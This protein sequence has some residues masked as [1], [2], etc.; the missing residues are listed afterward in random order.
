MDFREIFNSNKLWEFWP[1]SCKTR[2]ERVNATARFIIYAMVL[3]YLVGRDS[4]IFLLGIL[5]L[6]L[7][8]YFSSYENPLSGDWTWPTFANPEMNPL[9]FD[10]RTRPPAAPY[11]A[12][13]SDMEKIWRT[14]HPFENRGD[15]HRDCIN[16]KPTI[17]AESN[18]YTMP[19]TTFPNDQNAFAEACYGKKWRPMC[20][21]GSGCCTPDIY[22]PTWPEMRTN[23]TSNLI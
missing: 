18:F 11:W 2:G 5:A 4:R 7:L 19:C 14:T 17:N 9:V 13:Y 8:Y 15:T 6:C 1:S 16:Y 21:D 10:D 3:S 12:A 20:K 23:G 22:A